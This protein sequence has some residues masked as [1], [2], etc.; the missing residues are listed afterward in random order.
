MT[1]KPRTRI[2]FDLEFTGLHQFTTPISLALV[3]DN[4]HTFYAEFTDCDKSQVNQWIADNVIRKLSLGYFANNAW[5]GNA[6][7]GIRV[8]GNREYVQKHLITWLAQFEHSE[9]AG[10]V[11]LWADVPHYD[12]VLFCELFGGAM[13]LPKA[14]HYQCMD[15]ATMLLCHGID[16]D[17]SRSMFLQQVCNEH[18]ALDDAQTLRKCYDKL[19]ETAA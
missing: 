5:D 10:T 13:H 14:I 18:N 7:T 3:A 8:H 1:P 17:I 2:F 6:V 12:W 16:P 11:E 4:G 15:F 19:I 9:Q